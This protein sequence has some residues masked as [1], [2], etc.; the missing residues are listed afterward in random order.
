MRASQILNFQST[1]AIN[2]RRPWQTFKD[3][4]LWYGQSKSGS[5]RHALTTKQGN[6]HY[7]KGTRSSGIGRLNAAGRYI[8]NWDK[9]RTYVVPASLN[10]TNLKALVSPRTPQIKQKLEGYQDNWKSPEFALDSVID[11]VEYGENY[12]NQDLEKQEYLEK[13]VSSKLREQQ[14]NAEKN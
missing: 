8:V 7:Y 13:Y 12:S 9:V 6:K 14:E 11:F 4:Q 5:K 10:S 3:G 1:A 2:L